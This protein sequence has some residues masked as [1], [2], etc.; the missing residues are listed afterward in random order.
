MPA[1]RPPAAPPGERL[2]P[3][4]PGQGP[5]EPFRTAAR[6]VSPAYGRRLVPSSSGTR[7]VGAVGAGV[8]D[9]SPAFTRALWISAADSVERV[10]AELF[11]DGGNDAVVRLPGRDFPGVL[12]QGDTPGML[13]SAF[14][15][16]RNESA[17]RLRRESGRGA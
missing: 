4:G 9:C 14:C 8:R 11:T 7:S 6:H 16:R 13:R 3:P 15:R 5:A 1:R 2:P 17:P 12:I 10:E